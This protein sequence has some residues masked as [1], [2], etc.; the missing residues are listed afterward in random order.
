MPPLACLKLIATYVNALF[1]S[2]PP[3]ATINLRLW[4]WRRC[5]RKLI[6]EALV[7]SERRL[8]TCSIGVVNKYTIQN[9]NLLLVHGSLLIN[10]KHYTYVTKFFFILDL[11]LCNDSV[12][13]ASPTFG[14]INI[15]TLS[16][17]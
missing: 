1:S 14:N 13:A 3:L 7:L 15:V 8:I 9:V 6:A 16:F 17:L 10:I 2:V 12:D 4:F 5:F 11:F